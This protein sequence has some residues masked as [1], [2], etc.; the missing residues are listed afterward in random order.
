MVFL[1]NRSSKVV[2]QKSVWWD[3]HPFLTTKWRWVMLGGLG[4]EMSWWTHLCMKAWGYCWCWQRFRLAPSCTGGRPLCSSHLQFKV[5]VVSKAKLFIIIIIIIDSHPWKG[6]N[7]NNNKNQKQLP[8][9]GLNE[10]KNVRKFKQNTK[11]FFFIPL[12]EK[13]KGMS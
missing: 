7:N 9:S 3:L 2:Q 10:N 11:N 6:F 12:R 4:R 1:S 8:L 13:D 5:F